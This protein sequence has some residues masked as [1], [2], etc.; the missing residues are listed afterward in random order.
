MIIRCNNCFGEYDA[1]FA[2][3]P[4]CGF[5]EGSPG[6]EVYFL[7]PGAELLERYIVG[8]VLGYGGFGIIYK[9]WD[10]KLETVVAIKEFYP[11][12][13][14]KR[15]YGKKEVFLH[16]ENQRTEYENGIERFISEAQNL[17]KFGNHPNIVN[18]FEYFRENN[19]VYIV[20]EFLDGV[21]LDKYVERSGGKVDYQTAVEI[22]FC[23][24]YALNDIH[25]FDILHRDISPEN[26]IIC[27]NGTV[28]VIDLGAARFGKDDSLSEV[29]VKPGYAPP[30]QYDN[31]SYQG[32]ETDIYAIG[33]T[34]YTMLTGIRPEES[35]NRKTS[36]ELEK[37]SDVVSE[38]PDYLDSIVLKAMAVDQQFRFRTVEKMVEALTNCTQLR[39]V[40]DEMKLKSIRGYILTIAA[41]IVVALISMA[42]MFWLFSGE[43]V[44]PEETITFWCVSGSDFSNSVHLVVD[45]FHE[46][47]PEV[48]IVVDEIDSESYCDKLLGVL[49]SDEAPDIFEC[50]MVPDDKLNSYCSNVFKKC[51]DNNDI[52]LSLKEYRKC[53]PSGGEIPVGYTFPVIY[54]NTT[55]IDVSYTD[56]MSI[57]SII[58]IGTQYGCAVEASSNLLYSLMFGEEWE[59]FSDANDNG[60]RFEF[61]NGSVPIYIS[62]SSEYDDLLVDMAGRFEPVGIDSEIIYGFFSNELMVSSFCTDDKYE[63]AVALLT[64]M[65]SDQGQETM[66]I[67]N[68]DSAAPIASQAF[69]EYKNVYIELRDILPSMDNY[70]PIQKTGEY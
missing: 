42:M 32:P 2:I 5:I 37:P 41:G 25:S 46:L 67:K 36:D 30:E 35:T 34:L 12:R 68:N 33:A 47:H 49:G 4:H 55:T 54:V 52:L 48:T 62:D 31:I 60:E 8:R 64:Y 29:V 53:C 10:K 57:D 43:V 27:R 28:K 23:I 9:A 21:N 22:T 6:E 39:S 40:E 3:C 17:A 13:L 69:E 38:I 66:H 61:V 65:L 20:M 51:I 24:C 59:S 70:I 63:C 18:V 26:I 16:S 14:I 7:S 50:G 56:L 11:T 44:L 58:S 19:T 1:K 45:E 15:A